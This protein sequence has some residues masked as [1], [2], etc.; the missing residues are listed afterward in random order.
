[1]AFCDALAPSG[2]LNSCEDFIRELS[3]TFLEIND[4]HKATMDF[5]ELEHNREQTP[6]NP[7]EISRNIMKINDL[8]KAHKR[9]AETCIF[10]KTVL[11]VILSE[12]DRMVPSFH[13]QV[14]GGCRGGSVR[15][16][17]AFTARCAT[18]QA[19]LLPLS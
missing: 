4:L 10:A 8:R 1:M 13:L 7:R 12:P 19:P 14:E 15:D 16:W 18:E 9:W 17:H 6:Q 3:E 5:Q 11:L 2:L